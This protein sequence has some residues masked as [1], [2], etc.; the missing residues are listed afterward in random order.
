MITKPTVFILGAGAS[1]GFGYPSGKSLVEIIIKNFDQN[2]DNN[3][4][5]IIEGLGFSLEEILSFRD[6]LQYSAAPSIDSFL[7][8]RKEEERYLGKLAIANALIPCENIDP[9]FS[10]GSWYSLFFNML[11]SKFEVFEKN[12]VSF[13]TFNYDRSLEQF[14][15]TTL[16]KRYQKSEQ[17]CTLKLKK[18]PIIHFYGKLGLLPWEKSNSDEYTR[19]YNPEITPPNLRKSSKSLKIIHEKVNLDDVEIK[20]ARRMLRTAKKIYFLGFGYHK[21][22][23]DRL[24]IKNLTSS[25]SNSSSLSSPSYSYQPSSKPTI[26]GTSLGLSQQFKE[27]TLKSQKIKFHNDNWDINAWFENRIRFE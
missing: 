5:S 2:N 6:E 15:M 1:V 9:L 7:E 10:P 18:I 21:D 25:S 22:N 20:E 3:A 4:I 17:E 13:I 23:L 8:P 24:G 14:L 19:E 16:K 26:E 27:S 12:R 11:N